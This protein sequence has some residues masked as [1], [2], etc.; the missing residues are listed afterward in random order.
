MVILGRNKEEELG[1]MDVMRRPVCDPVCGQ[2]EFKGDI[3]ELR[4]F[5]F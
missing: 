2:H 3:I 1:D 5:V 4:A